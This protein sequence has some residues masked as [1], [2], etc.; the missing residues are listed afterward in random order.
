[1]ALVKLGRG[2]FLEVMDI[3]ETM[4]QLVQKE[5]QGYKVQEGKQGKQEGLV[6]LVGWDPQGKM[7]LMVKKEALDLQEVQDHQV[8]PAQEVN[9]D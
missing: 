4:A 6:N 8:S 3:K 1:M 5:A 2:V 9:L 7:A